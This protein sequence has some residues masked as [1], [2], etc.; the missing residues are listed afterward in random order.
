MDELNG[1]R[2]EYRMKSG[3][4]VFYLLIG[5]V[6]CGMGIFAAWKFSQLPNAGAAG[7]VGIG[8][9]AVGMYLLVMALRSRLTIE[10]TR[11]EMRGVFREKSADRSEVEGFRTINTRNG[12]YWRLELKQ[13]RG[14]INIMQW[15]GSDELNAWFQ[16]VIDLDEQDSTEVLTEIEQNPELGAT[17]EDR[18]AALKRAKTWNLGLSAIAVIAAVVAF[19]GAAQWQ[20]PAA[21]VLALTPLAVLYQLNRE[22]LLFALGKTRR[23]PRTDLSIALFI[24]VFGLFLVIV[25]TQFVSKIPMLP[26]M[27]VAALAFIG[28]FYML[29]RKGPLTRGFHGVVLMCAFFFGMGLIAACDTLLDHAKPAPYTAQVV[30]KHTSSG[31]S[32]TYYL[33][34]GAWGPFKGANTVSVPNSVYQAA[35]PGDTV[36]FEVY[37]GAL[38]AAWFERVACDGPTGLQTTP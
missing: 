14:H 9:A 10:G 37:P 38:R 20:L 8:P 6:M 11:I 36:C 12:T 26:A 33:D 1:N 15:F 29:G 13:G 7:L 32:T 25:Q 34:F 3:L 35:E 18:L 28:G 30:A 16:P 2:H 4:R 31:R 5:L 22:P 21:G 24:A 23:D 27:A 19:A 17:P